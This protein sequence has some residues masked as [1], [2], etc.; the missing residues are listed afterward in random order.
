MAAKDLIPL[1][2]NDDPRSVAIRAKIKGSSSNRRK[3]AQRLSG[4]KRMKPENLEKKAWALVADERLSAFEIE[5][6]IHEMLDRDDLKAE[7]RIRLIDSFIKAHS[8]VHGSKTKNLNL[9]INKVDSAKNL[10]KIWIEVQDER[11]RR[12]SKESIEK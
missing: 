6:L 5:R 2:G 3:A 12:D 4:I 10:R 1:K 11:R 8:A 7:L 9:N